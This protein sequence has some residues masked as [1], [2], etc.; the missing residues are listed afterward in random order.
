MELYQTN[1]GL[2]YKELNILL[3]IEAKCGWSD[4]CDVTGHNH[5]A[6]NE[7]MDINQTFKITESQ[8]KKLKFL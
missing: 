6:V 7:G 3:H 5:Y 2:G 4:F 8:A 1:S